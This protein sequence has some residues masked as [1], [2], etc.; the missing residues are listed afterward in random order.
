MD[1]R[2]KE[3]DERKEKI[4]LAA[5]NITMVLVQASRSKL[6]DIHWEDLLMATYLA[7]KAFAIVNSKGDQE[8]ANNMTRKIFSNVRRSEVRAVR[9]KSQ[10]EMDEWLLRE[11]ITSPP[12]DESLH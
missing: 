1:E 6:L 2:E 9:F 7:A 3:I 4:E 5:R 12:I 8:A 10:A 11:G